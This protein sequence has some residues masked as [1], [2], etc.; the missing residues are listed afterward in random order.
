M[1]SHCTKLN[2]NS[3]NV[4]TYYGDSD[5]ISFHI[6]ASWF[7]PP[8]VGKTLTNVCY[9]VVT[10]IPFFDHVDIFLKLNG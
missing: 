10:Y 9:S 6:Y 4:Y 5:V 8:Y 2:L 3:E 7:P 1:R